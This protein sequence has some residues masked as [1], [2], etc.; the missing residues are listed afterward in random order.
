[1]SKIAIVMA[2]VLISFSAV[3]VT[4]IPTWAAVQQ[5]R[6]FTTTKCAPA[7]YPWSQYQACET[8]HGRGTDIQWVSGSYTV[9]QPNPNFY[10]HWS[11]TGYASISL[12]GL[13]LR[14]GIVSF[15]GYDIVRHHFY[16]SNTLIDRDVPEKSQVCS[17]LNGGKPGDSEIKAQVCVPEFEF[18]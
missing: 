7:L 14:T 12:Y 15:S 17:T 4:S 3:T 11:F 10:A 2:T 16:L 13:S 5:N 8:I 6:S 18:W 1:M 9:R